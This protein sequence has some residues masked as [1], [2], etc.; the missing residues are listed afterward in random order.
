VL[1]LF[2]SM[3]VGMVCVDKSIFS[4]INRYLSA[5]LMFFI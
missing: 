3:R 1:L 4:K 2:T 5:R